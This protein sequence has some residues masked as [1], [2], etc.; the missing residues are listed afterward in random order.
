MLSLFLTLYM[1]YLCCIALENEVFIN[2][3]FLLVLVYGRFYFRCFIVIPFLVILV[4]VK[5]FL[6]FS[7]VF[8]GHTLP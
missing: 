4:L 7:T 3:L 1:D 6:L 5:Q 2:L 8:G